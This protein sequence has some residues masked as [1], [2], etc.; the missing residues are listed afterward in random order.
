MKRS[1]SYI[2]LPQKRGVLCVPRLGSKRIKKKSQAVQSGRECNKKGLLF[3]SSL[4]QIS[5]GAIG[6]IEEH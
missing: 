1:I 4:E 2:Y 6:D 5:T 3:F